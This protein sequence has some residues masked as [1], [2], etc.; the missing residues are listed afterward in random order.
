MSPPLPT[1]RRPDSA[2]SRI[3]AGRVDP[4]QSAV[5][6]VVAFNA[7]DVGLV[8][9]TFD[10]QVSG[11]VTRTKKVRVVNRG[12]APQTYDLAIDTVLDSPG[13]AFSLPGGASLTVPAGG[14]VEFDVQM[15]ADSSLMDHTRDPSLLP[16]QGVQA[17]FGD[18]P[19]NFLSEE[20]GSVTFSQGA[21]LKFRVPVYMAERPASMMSAAETIVTGGAGTGST[22]IALSGSGLCTGTL[23]AGPTCTGTFPNDVE[24]LVAPF[25]LQVVS[26]RDT[27]DAPDYADIQD[28]GVS[29][30]PGSP[31]S[32]NNDLIL[33]GVSSWGD[34]STLNEVAYDICVA[35]NED[36]VYD[37]NVVNSNPA[38]FVANASCNDNFVRVTQDLATA[39]FT[40]LGL[41]SFVNLVGPN[42]LDTALHLNNVMI[43]G[44]TP[45]QLG[46]LAGDT[47]FRY[48]VVTCPATN[49]GCARTT[50]ANDHCS[51]AVGVRYDLAAG[52]FSY[53]WAAQGLNFGGDFLDEDLN[54]NSLPVTWN[55]AN[56]AAN[57]SLGALLLHHHNKSSTRAEVVVL[58]LAQSA[59]LA[60]TQTATP[61]NPTLGQAV[62]VTLTITNNGPGTAA[63]V[64]LTD[65]LPDGLSYVSDDS[66]GAYDPSSGDW[67]AGALNNG[68]SATLHI[69]VTVDT[70]EAVTNTATVF[71]PD[72]PDPN[73]ANNQASATILA[74]RTAD[75]ALA[76]SVSSPTVLVGSPVS[77]T[78][79]ATNNGVD[80]SFAVNVQ[81]AFP[82]YPPL[83]PSSFTASQGSYDPSTG[84]WNLA[85]LGRGVAASLV[86]SLNAPNIAGPLTDQA[87]ALADT[88]DP[89]TA[90]NTASATTT[91]LSP[92]TV[93]GTKTV[94]GAFVEGGTVTYTVT[95]S[96]S[97]AFD[98][99]DNP[100][101]E[102]NDVLPSELTLVS[103]LATSGTATA[104]LGTNTVTWDGG[105]PAGGS[106]TITILATIN[107]GT[108][109][110]TVSNQGAISYDADGDG[111]NEASAVTDDPAVGGAADPTI[112]G[113]LTPT[114]T[115]T[116]TP[117]VSSTPTPTGT[118][119][120]LC[121]RADQ[122]LTWELLGVDFSSDPNSA[123][124]DWRVTNGCA[125]G[126]ARA[127]F[128]FLP[129]GQV[130][131]LTDGDTYNS[132]GSRA[133]TV[134]VVGA[135]HPGVAF[136]PN[137]NPIAGGQADRFVFAADRAGIDANTVLWNSAS[138]GG[139][140]AGRMDMRSGLCFAAPGPRPQDASACH[141]AS[142]NE[143][144]LNIT[145]TD[146]ERASTGF[147]LYRR[148]AGSGA[149]VK[150]NDAPLQA[151]AS[152]T[153]A[154]QDRCVVGDALGYRIEVLDRG[155]NP[156]GPVTDVTVQP[157]ST[158]LGAHDG[159]PQVLLV[160]LLLALLRWAAGA[161]PGERTGRP[162]A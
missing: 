5:G 16:T 67:T 17:N 60:V 81:E 125:Q 48:K 111:T 29:Y 18:Q 145:W 158:P 153:V 71:A 151:D 15:S 73:P 141:Q 35:T 40:I 87:N 135:P 105:V 162:P 43:L 10:P 46:M 106:V 109:G 19:R 115:A 107:V 44:A 76:M 128:R 49:P 14:S 70:T 8:S 24:S 12:L 47:T 55:V 32:V 143:W 66:G 132:P 72:P 30:L 2:P 21:T 154:V 95:L 114:P 31:P 13:V 3:G 53:N 156:Q 103:A 77:Y 7:E 82:A 120:P 86:F 134:D 131:G 110:A 99:Q 119:G 104:T 96:D 80:T 122:C 140:P 45:A 33:F 42:V 75:V 92:S 146:P 91:V 25:E 121:S 144:A 34:R 94:T 28:A 90:N 83:N 88:S 57:G 147:N 26:P 149:L 138:T 85:S 93:S 148:Q 84:L 98:Q 20:G 37:K 27:L 11:A 118:P 127:D 136:S 89:D 68:A 100:G 97:S 58:D 139:G 150:I 78:L 160:L 142:G 124:F 4:P 36:G 112:F 161:R 62:T 61:P 23:A 108:A 157:C 129:T 38:I 133:Y 50:G 116:A 101:S 113:V 117:T 9:V 39:G 54:G 79:T 137:S 126:L 59:D 155:G 65:P 1:Q 159:A 123:T 102:L 74:P 69:V 152:G 6:D 41:G 130:L 51:P 22:T 63:S 64:V 56:L 52:P